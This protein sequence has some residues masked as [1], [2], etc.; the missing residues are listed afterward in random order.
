LAAE[1]E[2]RFAMEKGKGKEMRKNWERERQEEEKK[3]GK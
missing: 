3:S 2:G 1:L